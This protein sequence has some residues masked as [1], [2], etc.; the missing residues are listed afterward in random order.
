MAKR[1]IPI[2]TPVENYE[3]SKIH[4]R[5]SARRASIHTRTKSSRTAKT[6]D[7]FNNI[8]MKIY[9]KHMCEEIIHTPM[10]D[11]Y[12]KSGCSG[13]EIV[14]VVFPP[15]I[16]IRVGAWRS[17]YILYLVCS[18][19]LFRVIV[20]SRQV[21][22]TWIRPLWSVMVHPCWIRVYFSVKISNRGRNNAK[23]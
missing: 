6:S 14:R 20:P 12:G 8:L 3:N 4:T 19:S 10:L 11:L 5:I 15:L 7:S 2:R 9:V 21:I 22:Y 13:L 16:P 17:F 1:T 18:F 23:S